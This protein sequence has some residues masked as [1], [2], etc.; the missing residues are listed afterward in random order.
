MCKSIY[1]SVAE[2]CKRSVGKS[3]ATMFI[4]ITTVPAVPW[5]EAQH[6]ACVVLHSHSLLPRWPHVALP[7]WCSVRDHRPLCLY[8]FS[9]PSQFILWAN[10]QKLNSW[11]PKKRSSVTH[12]W[13]F[14]SGTPWQCWYKT[15]SLSS[16]SGSLLV[17]S[18]WEKYSTA[19]ALS[20]P[21][22]PS[23]PEA[24]SCGGQP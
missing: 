16:S 18:T 8:I 22:S 15:N 4:S 9:F 12:S 7:W 17:A 19:A 6:T 5:G 1:Y 13:L 3:T 11:M 10:C 14:K 23:Q 21:E 20:F 24:V 2:G